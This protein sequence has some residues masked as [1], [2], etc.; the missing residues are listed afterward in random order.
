LRQSD[1]V[2]LGNFAPRR[3]MILGNIC[4]RAAIPAEN[5]ALFLAWRLRGCPLKEPS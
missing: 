2:S 3:K 5:P 4:R 1:N